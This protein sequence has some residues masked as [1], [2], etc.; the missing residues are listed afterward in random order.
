MRYFYKKKNGKFYG[1]TS[2]NYPCPEKCGETSS[3]PGHNEQVF[4]VD[5]NAWED[6]TESEND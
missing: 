1:A 6:K 4:N 3:K 5:L 2:E